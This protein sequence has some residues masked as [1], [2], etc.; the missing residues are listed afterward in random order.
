MRLHSSFKVKRSKVKITRPINAHTHRAT[1]LPN[2]KAYELR[3]WYMDGG[4]QPASATGAMASKVKCQGRK[5][6]WSVWAFLA[7]C[8]ACVIRG[9]RGHTMSAKPS[10]HTSCL[11][12]TQTKTQ[13]SLTCHAQHQTTVL[14]VKYDSRINCSHYHIAYDGQMTS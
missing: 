11:Y 6:T 12:I 3:T 7:Q 13:P 5:V 14:A 9:R 4:R 1:Y 2:G 10:G 8:C